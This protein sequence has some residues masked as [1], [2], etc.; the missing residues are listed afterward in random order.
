MEKKTKT[1]TK[2]YDV[3]VANDGKEFSD[4]TK[5]E[6]HEWELA[7]TKVYI[8]TRR[9][10]RSDLS[11]IYSTEELALKATEDST[12]HSINIIYLDQRFWNVS[13]EDT[14]LQ[15]ARRYFFEVEGYMG[16]DEECIARYKRNSHE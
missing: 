10:Q 7:A 11:E 9:G 4:K 16:T 14:T 1:V 12:V 8:V 2:T 13:Q 5:C 6:Q 15:K 3:Y